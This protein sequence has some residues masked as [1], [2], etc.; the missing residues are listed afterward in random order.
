[1]GP[2]IVVHGGAGREPA[3][4]RTPR[5][6]GVERAADAGLAVLGRGG[7]AL[8]AVIEAVATLEDDPHFNAGVGAVLTVEGVV[9]LDASVMTGDTLAAGAVGAV[10]GVPNPVRLARAVLDE[11]REVLLVGEP[12]AAL[13]RRRGFATIAPGALVTAAARRR[14]RARTDAPGETVGAVARD[15]RGHVAAATSTGGVAGKRAGRVGDSA[16]IG[17]GTYADDRLGAGSATGPGEAIIRAALVRAALERLGRGDTPDAAA[18]HALGVLRS[19]LA[20]TAGLILVDPL[21]RT[22]MAH[23]TESMPVAVRSLAALSRPRGPVPPPSGRGSGR[24]RGRTPPG[25]RA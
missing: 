12:A 5:R 19:R 17:A 11:G 2:V 3:A 7:T 22:G 15:A 13:A 21:G 4:E 20:A 16:V 24:A 14:W 9:E 18:A 6:A 23:T 25:G 1:M 10:R 8:D